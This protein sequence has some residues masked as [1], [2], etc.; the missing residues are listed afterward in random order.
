[1]QKREICCSI[2]VSII[3]YHKIEA[4]NQL[5][6]YS[7]NQPEKILG[8]TGCMPHAITALTSTYTLYCEN[9]RKYVLSFGQMLGVL[10]IYALLL[11]WHAVWASIVP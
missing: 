10:G 7:S 5:E 6:I 9:E 8:K 1:M 4:D 2:A 11:I 3:L